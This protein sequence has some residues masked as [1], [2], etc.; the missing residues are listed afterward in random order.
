MS[1]NAA[2]ASL[3]GC[4]G[5]QRRRAVN[6]AFLFL[7]VVL[8]GS[9]VASGA[10]AIHWNTSWGVYDHT[11][12]DL[13]GGDHFLLGSCSAKW[14]LIYAG[15]NNAIDPPNLGNAA[16]GWTSGDDVVLGT[17]SIPLGGG[18]APEDGTT[19]EQYLYL[20]SGDPTYVNMSWTTNGYVYQRLYEGPLASGSWFVDSPLLALNTAWSFEQAPQMFWLDEDY[21]GVQPNQQYFEVPAGQTTLILSSG[22]QHLI[23][24]DYEGEPADTTL[25]AQIGQQVPPGSQFIWMDVANQQYR[26]TVTLDRQGSWGPRGTTT[27]HRGVAY[28]LRIPPV[29]GLVTSNQYSVTLSGQDPTSPAT[30]TAAANMAVSPLGYP[31]PSNKTFGTMAMSAA[32]P[33]GSYVY[34]WDAPSQLF[35]GGAK[36]S[37]GWAAA[38]SNKLVNAGE[39]YFFRNNSA[40]TLNV[41]EP[42]P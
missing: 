42:L 9:A 17:R 19:W 40:A 24:Y 6:K 12:V 5:M 18:L 25:S 15:P 13:T 30:L 11:A 37:K 36:S 33:I 39:G 38:F 8:G 3:C 4:C 14:Q 1:S 26:S 31:Y 27:L 34:F 28:W 2:L 22:R 29:G 32:A 23:R 41:V 10:I 21:Q 20:E 35:Y 16:N 7:I